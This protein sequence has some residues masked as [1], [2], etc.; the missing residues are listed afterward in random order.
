VISI[1]VGTVVSYILLACLLSFVEFHSEPICLLTLD[2]WG[3][4]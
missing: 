2:G 1:T 3:H 4:G